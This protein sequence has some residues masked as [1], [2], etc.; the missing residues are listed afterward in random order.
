VLNSLKPVVVG[1]EVQCFD[2]TLPCDTKH[3]PMD[4]RLLTR[5]DE[6]GGQEKSSSIY[7]ENLYVFKD[8]CSIADINRK[9]T[10]CREDEKY[11]TKDVSYL[12]GRQRLNGSV[13]SSCLATDTSQVRK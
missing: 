2:F 1:E 6:E 7:S 13:V 3:T 4:A 11:E 9:Y 8:A 5:V 12:P 10:K